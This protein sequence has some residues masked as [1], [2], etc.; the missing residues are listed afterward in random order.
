MNLNDTHPTFADAVVPGLVSVILPTYNRASILSRAIDSVLTQTYA[1]IETVVVDD[2]STDDTTEVLRQYG[3]RI[4][5]LRQEN[6][7][8][9]AARNYGITHSNGE[10]IAFLD[11]DDFWFNWKVE[12]EVAALRRHS[13]AG[14]VW[15]DM[16]AEN[17]SGAIFS[18]RFLRRM[19]GAYHHDHVDLD[20]I[21]TRVGTL[22]DV[23][24]SAPAA[25]AGVPLRVGDLSSHI[26]M[27]NL[28]HTPTVLYRRSWAEQTGGFDTSW[29]NGGDYEYYTRLCALGPAIFIDASSIVYH[30]GGADQ[31]T[32][33]N[34]MLS[35]ARNDL[36]TVQAR[37]SEPGRIDGIPAERIRSRLSWS[38]S[39]VGAMEF[40]L[41]HRGQAARKFAASLRARPALD[42]RLLYLALCGLPGPAVDVLRA[43][44]RAI[45]R[46]PSE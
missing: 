45:R 29:I 17:A 2:G 10:F 14:L 35:M 37:V 38:L 13:E 34:R 39:W 9:G 12:A 1:A 21:M 28:L 32:A 4:R 22:S 36:R 40:E 46:R 26:L 15:T 20:S 18:E 25:L 5:V 31:L 7:G 6:C 33:P 23:L 43:V 42:R 11:S 8:V 19:Y 24:P 27:G 41:G 44:R 16:S 30:T 3:G